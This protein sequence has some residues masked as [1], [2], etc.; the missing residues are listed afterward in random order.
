LTLT[1]E[2]GLV[3]LK[4]GFLRKTVK[5]SR[6]QTNYVKNKFANSQSI[7]Q[8]PRVRYVKIG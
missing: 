6:K 7:N 3:N 2:E 5:K 1:G 8:D 4:M